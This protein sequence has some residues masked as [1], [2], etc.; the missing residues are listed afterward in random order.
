M[1]YTRVYEDHLSFNISSRFLGINTTLPDSRLMRFGT[2]HVK[3]SIYHPSK[4]DRRFKISLDTVNPTTVI[5]SDDLRVIEG[6]Y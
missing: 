4:A 6:K 2:P 3:F 1:S 5:Q